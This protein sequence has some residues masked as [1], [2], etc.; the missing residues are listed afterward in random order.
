MPTPVQVA[1]GVLKRNTSCLLSKRAADAHQGDLWEFPG[2]KVEASESVEQALQ[3]ELH[4]ELGILVKRS[5]PLISIEH[6]YADKTVVLHTYLIDEFSGEPK[7]CEQQ[8]LQWVT[9]SELHKF[10]LPE[11]NVAIV[12]ALQQRFR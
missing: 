6:C 5:T 10:E 1:V 11:A 12:N 7:G 3:R 8:P 4:E 9:I 2:G